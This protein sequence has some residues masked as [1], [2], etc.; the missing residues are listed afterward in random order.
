MRMVAILAPLFAIAASAPPSIADLRQAIWSA[1]T[2]PP[3]AGSD[4]Q[5]VATCDAARAP[6]IARLWTIAKSGPREDR[7]PALTLIAAWG[8]P[9]PA[10]RA[11]LAM[12]QGWRDAGQLAPAL[13]GAFDESRAPAKRA[14]LAT[15]VR[16]SRSR[17]VIGS[18]RYLLAAQTLAQ[19]PA[20]PR[21]LAEL[22]LVRARY[23]DV[24]TTLLGA[25]DPPRLGTV[26][27]ALQFRTERLKPGAPLPPMAARDLDGQR[28]SSAQFRGK[29]TLIDFWATWCPPC[30]AAMPELRRV[31]ASLRGQAFQIVSI[32]G[33]AS[34]ATAK[35]FVTRNGNAWPQ[36]QVG[37]SGV[38][39]P[40]WSNSSFPFYILIDRHG[41]IKALGPTLEPVLAALRKEV[42][43]PPDRTRS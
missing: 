6:I 29:V 32:S 40:E 39:S 33:D 3:A 36:W 7:L 4:P 38:V 15:L 2:A 1:C 8:P 19:A 10:Q 42:V 24:P 13:E 37:P 18:A 30:V 23:G 26:A 14:V 16:T 21:A 17:A 34:A 25:G 31:A 22:R 9:D 20:R 27:A 41:T 5:A 11:L 43:P 12:A 28:V 35:A